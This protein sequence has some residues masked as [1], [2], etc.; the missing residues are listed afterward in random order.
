M[1]E[2][3]EKFMCGDVSNDL[4]YFLFTSVVAGIVETKGLAWLGAW[5]QDQMLVERNNS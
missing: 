2:I 3:L 1:A 5:A 4:E